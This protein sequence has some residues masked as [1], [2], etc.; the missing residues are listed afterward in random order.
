MGHVETMRLRGAIAGMEDEGSIG[1][2]RWNNGG[3]AMGIVKQ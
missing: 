3:G 2:Q 1:K